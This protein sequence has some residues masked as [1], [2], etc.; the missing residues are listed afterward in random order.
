MNRSLHRVLLALALS[1]AA[2]PA[3]GGELLIDVQLRADGALELRYA[4]PAGVRELPFWDAAPDAHPRWR[5]ALFEAGDECTEATA[6][7][8]R[9]RDGCAAATL[10]V[11]PRLVALDAVYEPAQPISD[12]SGVLMYAGHYAVLLPGHALHW[13]WRAPQGGYLLHLGQR[14][15]ATVDQVVPAE[16]VDRAL[17]SGGTDAATREVGAHQVVFLGRTRVDAVAGGWLVVDPA[18]DADRL[19]RIRKSLLFNVATLTRAFGTPPRGSFAVVT[20][21]SSVPGFHGDTS[22]G[23]MMRLRLNAAPQMGKELEHFVAHESA[24][25]WNNGL[26]RSDHAQPWLHEGNAEW[27][28]RLLM[29]EAGDIDDGALRDA[30]EAALNRCAA[31]RRDRPAA[32]IKGRRGDDSYACGMSLMLLAHAQRAAAT[33]GERHALELMAGLQ[34]RHPALDAA[35]FAQ[36]ADDRDDG[37]GPMGRLLLDPAQGFAAGFGA[38]LAALGLAEARDIDAQTALPPD[39]R[40]RFGMALMTALMERDCGGRASFWV[41]D[42][43]L[44]LDNAKLGCERLPVGAEVVALAGR[45]VLDAPVAAWQAARAGC[46]AA[47]K[48]AVGYRDGSVGEL[49]CPQAL[50]AM[51]LRQ[52]LR[53]TPQALDRLGLTRPRS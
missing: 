36:W 24:H 39:L 1:I 16:V 27:L 28:S 40:M 6:T 25:W 46:A 49:T 13:R 5:G 35:R 4:P 23:Q 20:A 17:A 45:P 11:R 29:R 26:Y 32:T 19:A 31:A 51:P 18:L 3:L 38:R 14:G 12:G 42:A 50:P 41:V 53:L 15:E 33:A 30:I 2:L 7:G 43:A 52:L 44:K 47:G 48:L 8:L 22:S 37:R 9:L 10:R 34:R 21:I